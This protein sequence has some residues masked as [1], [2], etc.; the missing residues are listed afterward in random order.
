MKNSYMD[1]LLGKEPA[2]PVSEDY[3]GTTFPVSDNSKQLLLNTTLPRLRRNGRNISDSEFN[4]LIDI[5]YN[6]FPNK[7]FDAAGLNSKI[8][9]FYDK[10]AATGKDYVAIKGSENPEDVIPHELRHLV[11]Q[12]LPLTDKEKGFLIDAYGNDFLNLRNEYDV[13]KD[14]SDLG[15]EMVTLNADAR[16]KLLGNYKSKKIS[17]DLQDKIIDKV[18]DEKIVESIENASGYGKR[19]V[20]SLRNKNLLTPERIKSFR[21][22]MKYVGAAAPIGLGT[23]TISK[24]KRGGILKGQEGL[25]VRKQNMIKEGED[26]LTH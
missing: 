13:F 12:H 4:D 11:D 15:G 24:E 23:A 21:E 22:A 2:L 6:T 1:V 17:I 14:M 5:T 3:L 8:I 26:W 25:S 18:P 9:G 10:N 20:E 16:E 19:F 7:T